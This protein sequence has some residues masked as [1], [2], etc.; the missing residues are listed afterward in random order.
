MK[1][2]TGCPVP[3]KP[4]R[5]TRRVKVKASTAVSFFSILL[6]GSMALQGC[7]TT[8]P[9]TWTDP[10]TGLTWEL[11]PDEEPMNRAEAEAHCEALTTDGGGW[12]LPTIGELRTLIRG[13]ATTEKNGA[14]NIAE[15]SCVDWSCRDD[16][17]DGCSVGGGPTDDCVWPDENDG[18]CSC[19]WPAA[20]EGICSVYWSSSITEDEGG[21]GIV[22][23][24]IAGV[25]FYNVNI[26]DPFVRCVR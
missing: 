23:F 7:D 2:G 25:S 22:L 9:S 19:Y 26:G 18:S 3:A 13:C 16:P 21:A 24:Q 14:C 1:P 15:E 5:G 20:I 12:R 6:L 17:C 11:S 10:K 8:P 4:L